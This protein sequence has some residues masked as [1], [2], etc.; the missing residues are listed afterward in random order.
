MNRQECAKKLIIE[1]IKE[2]SNTLLR[3]DEETRLH[4]VLGGLLYFAT[5]ISGAVDWCERANI[6]VNCFANKR[7]VDKL[8]AKVKLYSSD[9]VIPFDQ[10]KILMDRI[11]SVEKQYWIDL[12]AQSGI[13]CPEF[14]IP[15]IGAYTANGHYIGNT[16]EYAYEYSPLNPSCRPILE[17]IGGQDKENSLAYIFAI[18]IGQTIQELHT[19]ITG[20][21]YVSQNCIDKKIVIRDIDFRLSNRS[22]FEK[23]NAIFAFN[24]CCRINYLLEVF[25]QLCETNSFLAFRMMYITFY[26]LEFDLENFELND[27][28]YNMPYRDDIFR[29]AMAHYS[30]FGKIDDSEI[31]DNVIGY[32]LF[33]KFFNKPFEIVNQELID[34]LIITRNSL[35]KFVKI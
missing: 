19:K 12:Q 22:Y 17:A 34:E 13:W 21:K 35:E 1:D 23:D 15:D 32:G 4:F 5:I 25:S 8:R 7:I 24:L 2:I 33:E 29:N 28:H 6:E 27:I 20:K 14:I 26:H 30:L 18:K 16:L 11:V 31:I 10:Q 9:S 3:C